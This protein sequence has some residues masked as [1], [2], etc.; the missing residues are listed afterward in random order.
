MNL[1]LLAQHF[2]LYLCSASCLSL[3]A[4]AAVAEPDRNLAQSEQPSTAFNITVNSSHDGPNMTDDY[5][6]LRE[7]IELANGSLSIEDLSTA[8]HQ[9]IQP[10]LETSKIVFDLPQGDTRIRLATP[11]PQ[12]SQPGLSIDGSSQIIYPE[13]GKADVRFAIPQPTIEITPDVKTEIPHGFIINAD[14]IAIRGLSIYGFSSKSASDKA[15]LPANI[16]IGHPAPFPSITRQ[17][18][19]TH[20]QQPIENSPPQGTTIEDNWIGISA[21]SRSA[22]ETSSFGVYIFNSS[23]ATIRRN[24]ISDH[25]GSGI[26]TGRKSENTQI[27]NN[28]ITYNG[29]SGIS[30]AVRMTGDVTGSQISNN[31]ICGNDGSGIY[32]FKPTG[33]V[34]ISD[35]I[36]RSN[37]RRLRRAAIYVMGSDHQ[38]VGNEITNQAGPGVVVTGYRQGGTTNSQRNLIKNNRFDRIEGL[39][40]DLITRG[41]V[42]VQAFQ[43]G[44][45]PNPRRNSVH[46]RW[47]TGNSAIN[48]PEFSSSEFYDLN[49]RIIIRGI[50]DPDSWVQLYRTSGSRDERGPLNY[51]IAAVET[52]ASGEFSYETSFLE[53]GDRLSAIATDPKYGTS[54][55]AQ[56]TTIISSKKAEDR[57]TNFI[58]TS[59]D[60]D[61]CQEPMEQTHTSGTFSST[62]R[63]S[64]QPQKNDMTR[65]SYSTL[66]QVA[67]TMIQNRSLSLAMYGHTDFN[68]GF[69]YGST[70]AALRITAVRDYLVDHGV[71]PEKITLHISDRIPSHGGQSSPL[72]HRKSAVELILTSEELL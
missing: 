62:Y 9:Q 71:A 23:E 53:T 52:N 25:G 21:Q 24:H 48:A 31:L 1:S 39:S 44:D 47:E 46:R 66:Q 58:A 6:T 55:P 11:L 26:I 5:L 33:S 8:E 35:N 42:G 22:R 70:L 28:I 41:N 61:S 27:F 59:L 20:I 45:G 12:L 63:L 51:P 67:Q 60:Q 2:Y 7:A 15:L 19:N 64:F 69:S 34:V 54:E 4:S 29:L 17:T 68:S 13:A 56:N 36:L 30:D 50:A 37:G 10:A 65:E 57:G 72:Y 43:Q 38:I 18:A 14:N 40:I 32:L 49:D 3:L 16:V